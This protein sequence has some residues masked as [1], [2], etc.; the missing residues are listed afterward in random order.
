MPSGDQSVPVNDCSRQRS[1]KHTLIDY[2]IRVAKTKALIGDLS[3]CFRMC[4][5]AQIK[6][7]MRYTTGFS[8]GPYIIFKRDESYT[9]NNSTEVVKLLISVTRKTSLEI[10]YIWQCPTCKIAHKH[11]N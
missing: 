1:C 3:L 5:K 10:F 8:V 7:T 11:D 6:H 9:T 4:K 2:A